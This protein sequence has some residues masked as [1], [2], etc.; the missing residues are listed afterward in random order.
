MSASTSP[1]TLLY[2][3]GTAGLVIRVRNDNHFPVTIGA[4]VRTSKPIT[5][6]PAHSGC[7]GSVLDTTEDDDTFDVNW[8]LA[9]GEDKTFTL[10][11]AMRMD[12]NAS[13]A[14]QGAAFSIP[15][16]ITAHSG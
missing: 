14:C 4:V 9:V 11:D 6:D 7:P 10:P 13:N 8:H 5:T 1:A 15:I 12:V 16:T 3:G 2:P